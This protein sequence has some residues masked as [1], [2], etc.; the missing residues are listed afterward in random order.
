MS[1]ETEKKTYESMFYK[2]K[3]NLDSG[4]S[5]HLHLT[6]LLFVYHWNSV[7]GIAFALYFETSFSTVSTV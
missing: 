1:T 6:N 3:L 4:Q 7:Q 2:E 5:G